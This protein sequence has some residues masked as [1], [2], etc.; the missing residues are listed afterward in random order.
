METIMPEDAAT[1]IHQR[2]D[3]LETT[4]HTA[5]MAA[6]QAATQ[7]ASQSETLNTLVRKVDRVVETQ[8]KTNE[9]LAEMV[10]VCKTRAQIV[11]SNQSSISELWKRNKIRDEN[12]NGSGSADVRWYQKQLGM[13]V[14]AIVA[15][16]MGIAAFIE[17]FE[18]W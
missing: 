16:L 14:M 7:A 3:S 10:G 9:Q 4:L 15:V 5:A 18:G 12:G 8:S 1:R 6:T 2:I 17:H 11:A 13:I